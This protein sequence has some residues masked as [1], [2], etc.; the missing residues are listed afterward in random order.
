MKIGVSTPIDVNVLRPYL[1]I[2]ADSVFP[3]GMGAPAITPLIQGLLAVGHKVSIYSLD[4]EVTT[5]IILRGPQLTIYIGHYRP[6]AR[7]RCPDLFR[8]EG[9]VL[10]RFIQQDQP[11]IVHAHWAYEYALGAILSGYPHLITLHDNPWVVLRYV[12]D[13][14]R[15]V[16]LLLKLLVLRKGENF[17]AVSPYLAKALQSSNRIPAVVPNA[18]RPAP[19]HFHPFPSS[20]RRRIVS[21]T[22]EWSSLKNVSTALFAFR[23]VRRQLGPNIEYWLYGGDYGL[24]GKVHRWAEAHGVAEGVH[25]AGK[26]SHSDMINILPSFDVLLHPSREESF[27]MTLVEA[28]QAG[29]PVVAGNQSGAVPWVLGGG[30]YGV[31][32]DINSPA[33]MA[34][35]LCELLTQ[36]ELYERLSSRGMTMVQEHFSIPIV[37]AAYEAQYR[38][39]LSKSAP[40]PASLTSY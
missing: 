19:G 37:T 30:H 12:P 1:D 29:V 20:T 40:Q 11:D 26:A 8:E 25:F 38:R 16:R 24:N 18:V 27:G 9:K 36:P 6:R 32:T 4:S 35:S 7:Q 28:M 14:Y 17:S 5:P 22:A 15:V 2:A 23:E 3:N 21:I 13:A 10:A 39:V 34:E 31:L 33:A